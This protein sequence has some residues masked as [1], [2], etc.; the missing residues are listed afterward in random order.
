MFQLAVNYRSHGGIVNCAHSVI[1]LITQFWPYTIDHLAPEQ[2][3]VDG[4]KPIFLSA[5]DQNMAAYETFL[6]GDK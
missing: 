5:Q 2:G 3:I 6:V 4:L 1:Q